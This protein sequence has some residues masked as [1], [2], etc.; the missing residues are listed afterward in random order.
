MNKAIGIFKNTSSQTLAANDNI[1]FSDM[2]MNSPTFGYANNSI[3]IR[4]PGLYRVDANFTIA[5][6]AAGTV[7]VDLYQSGTAN[8]SASAVE[9]I[10]TASDIANLKFSTL[11]K[12]NPGTTW[13]YANLSFN[14]VTASTCTLASV[15]VEKIQ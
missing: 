2:Q 6:T 15:I 11:V 9:T 12:V 14:N 10:A 13:N 7:E 3:Q 5:G 1:G 4:T 8:S